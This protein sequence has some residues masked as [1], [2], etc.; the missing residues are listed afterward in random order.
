MGSF[1]TCRLPSSRITTN[2]LY[3][4]TDDDDDSTSSNNNDDDD[5]DNDNENDE[6]NQDEDLDAAFYREYQK[7][8]LDK[9]GWDLPPDQLKAA[10]ES[11]ESEF[12]KAMKECQSDY[13][14]AKEESMDD[15]DGDAL[16]AADFF[17]EQIK[18]EEALEELW[19][20]QQAE[21]VDDDDEAKDIEESEKQDEDY[22][23]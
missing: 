14:N 11:A 13:E 17:L 2:P 21:D 3:A 12:L 10:A 6:N 22:F 7:A 23:Q 19:N 1:S 16:S 18:K 9:L 5:D 8:K 4:T 15:R 20:K